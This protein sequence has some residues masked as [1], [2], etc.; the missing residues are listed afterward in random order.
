VANRRNFVFFGIF[1]LVSFNYVDRV[2]LSIAGPSIART[3]KISPVGMGYLFSSFVWLYFVALIPWGIVTDRLGARRVN[4]IGVT[5]WSCATLLT[6]LAWSFG[7]ILILRIVMGAAEASTYPGS[8][9]ALREWAPRS[10]YG[11]ASTMLNSGGYF[12]PALGTFLLSGVVALTNWRIGFVVA[13]LLCLVWLAAWLV[14]YEKPEKAKYIDEKE[15]HFILSRRDIGSSSAQASTTGLSGLLRSPTMWALA[16]SQG[17]AVYTQYL[18]LTWLPS[19]LSIEKHMSIIKTGLFTAAPYLIATVL[20]LILA[21]ASDRLLTPDGALSGSRRSAVTVALLSAS[22]VLFAPLFNNNYAILALITISLASLATAISLNIALTADL[23][24]LPGDAGK[25]MGIQIAGGNA[26]GLMAPIV[27]GYIIKFTG[28]YNA[29]FVVAGA[30]L[31][32]GAAIT[33]TLTR[34]PIED[35][36]LSKAVASSI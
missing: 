1:L 17:S 4:A 32:V 27:T 15:R 7:S 25:A 14:W 23:L 33:M 22:V 28:N 16:L 30:L 26:F 19:Y 35:S 13:A 5:I 9:R 29:A 8:G 34:K 2:A 18:F 20:S 3:F 24:K 11:F 6:S 12:G 10:E 21:A 36:S 31:L